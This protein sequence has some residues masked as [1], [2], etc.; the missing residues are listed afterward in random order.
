MAARE[1]CNSLS[2]DE[3]V[4]VNYYHLKG[5]WRMLAFLC[6]D[7]NL[8]DKYFG[9]PLQ[10]VEFLFFARQLLDAAFHESSL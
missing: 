5:Q 1:V 8:L 2:R 4:N 10:V 3:C 9:A 7:L 6:D